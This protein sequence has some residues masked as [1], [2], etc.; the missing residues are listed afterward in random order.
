MKPM[1]H[2]RFHI[3]LSLAFVVTAVIGFAPRYWATGV[4]QPHPLGPLLHMHALFF[5]A[6][7]LLLLVQSALVA[8]RRVSLHRRLGMAG[9]LL[10][11]TMVP[12]GLMTAVAAARRALTIPGQ[13][14]T[15]LL[16][17]QAGAIVLF[18]GFVGAGLWHKRHP[19][20]HRR[21]IV[22]AT[23]CL[24]PPA[25]VRLPL[26]GM[27]PIPALLLSTLFVVAGI[28]HDLRT[29][30]RVHP[31]YVWG[32]LVVLVSAPL[33]FALAQTSAWQSF[34]RAVRH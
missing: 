30:G 27:A 28:V 8:V 13:D 26:P 3:G 18:A 2:R 11:V 15:T 7:L 6:W 21:L 5:T 24:I 17:F 1:S 32:G 25:I 34:A 23:V 33:R 16:C 12:L 22:L 29:R 20:H 4:V 31:V 10:A 14:P 19:E 9:A